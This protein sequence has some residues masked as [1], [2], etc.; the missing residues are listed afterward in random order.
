MRIAVIS[1]I[2]STAAPFRRA[3]RNARE[4]GFDQLVI[5]G[6]LF[7][8]GVDPGECL[9]LAIEAIDRDGAFLIGG[10]HEQLYIDLRDRR[11]AYIDKLP[12]W[13][14]ESVEWTWRELGETWPARL[15]WIPEWAWNKVLFAHAN[16]FGYGDWTY[17]SDEEL[18]KAAGTKLRERGFRAGVFGHLHR[19]KFYRDEHGIEVHVV[20]SIGQPRSRPQ[21]NP[22]WTMIEISGDQLSVQSRPIEFDTQAHRSGINATRGLSPETKSMLCR[23]YQ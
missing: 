6:D 15:E 8:Y 20:D 19:P 18:L 21:A 7:T 14:R 9:D 13:I 5:L 2:H 17:L 16:P 11:S 4:E 10:N 1:D 12:G 3:L 22:A 23:F